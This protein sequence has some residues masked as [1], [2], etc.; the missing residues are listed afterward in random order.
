MYYLCNE[1]HI[2]FSILSNLSIFMNLPLV[3][4]ASLQIKTIFKRY[5]EFVKY[6]MS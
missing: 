1:F 6:Q 4:Y 5:D 2:S 3:M